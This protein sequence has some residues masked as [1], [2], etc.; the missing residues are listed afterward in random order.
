L[1]KAWHVRIPMIVT[2]DSGIV[3]SHSGIVTTDS[4]DRDQGIPARLINDA[5]SS[6]LR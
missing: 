6:T 3:T 4:G 1:K 5:L 2:A